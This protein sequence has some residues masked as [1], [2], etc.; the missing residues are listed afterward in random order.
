MVEGGWGQSLPP[1]TGDGEECVPPSPGGG[2]DYVP[3]SPVIHSSRRKGERRLARVRDRRAR[4]GESGH[5]DVPVGSVTTPSSKELVTKPAK[6]ESVNRSTVSGASNSEGGLRPGLEAGEE[7]VSGDS[8]GA[9]GAD[10]CE[11]PAE[12]VGCDDPEVASGCDDPEVA[13]S[14]DDPNKAPGCDD[15]QVA[16]GCDDPQ[17]ASG[18]DNLEAAAG[19][20]GLG[21][22]R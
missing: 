21:S 18:C 7:A 2:E 16:A 12:A 3:P 10:C 9:K 4:E 5:G 1:S 14:C 22:C 6:G 13:S 19:C 20:D 15:P 17:E 11:V 8:D